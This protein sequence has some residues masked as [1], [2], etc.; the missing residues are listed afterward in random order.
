MLCSYKN[1]YEDH[2]KHKISIF[3]YFK[4]KAG[5]KEYVK[6]IHSIKRGNMEFPL[7]LSG[8]ESG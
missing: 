7:R 4:N 2:E 5:Y 6:K 1:I 8:K 3:L